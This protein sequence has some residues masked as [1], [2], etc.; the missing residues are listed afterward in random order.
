LTGVFGG[1][2]RLA[3]RSATLINEGDLM[4]LVFLY[5]LIFHLIA[6]FCLIHNNFI[7]NPKN[8]GLSPKIFKYFSLPYFELKLFCD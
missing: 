5:F 2:A 3:I 8:M 6:L 1:S 7:F 4:A